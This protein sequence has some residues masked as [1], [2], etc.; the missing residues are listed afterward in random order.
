MFSMHS[1]TLHR[2]LA[3][4]GVTFKAL[5][6]ETRLEI[7]RR[8]LEDSTTPISQIAEA[9]DYADASAFTRAFRRWTETTPAAWRAAREGRK[10][11]QRSRRAA[12]GAA[13]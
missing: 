4:F 6:D 8:M 2:R 12:S 13:G 1:R 5:A 10:A 7:A 11:K 3:D 9:L